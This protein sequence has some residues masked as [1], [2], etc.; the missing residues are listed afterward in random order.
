MAE[1]EGR[2]MISEAMVKLSVGEQLFITAEEG[3][4]SIITS[5]P[6][7]RLAPAVSGGLTAARLFSSLSGG[8]QMFL[9]DATLS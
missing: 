3:N 5:E 2:E 8:L 7:E 4:V 9:D 1:D 6:L